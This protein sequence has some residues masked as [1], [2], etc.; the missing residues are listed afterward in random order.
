MA[1]LEL[2]ASVEDDLGR[3][4]TALLASVEDLHEPAFSTR[5]HAGAWSAAHVFEHLAR[6][7]SQITRGARRAVESGKGAHR[8]FLDPVRMIP[9][10]TG[11]AGMVRVRTVASLDPGEAPP[12]DV[13]LTRI[14]ES[15]VAMLELLGELGDRNTEGIYLRHPFFGAFPVLEMLRWVGWHELRHRRQI[16]RIRRTLS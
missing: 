7:E 2:I 8:H 6:V 12:R 10:R 4:R 5:P 15:R 13:A 3:A 11:L 16:F 9:F 1:S 14:G